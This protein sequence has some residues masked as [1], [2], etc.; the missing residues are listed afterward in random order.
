MTMGRTRRTIVG[1]DFDMSDPFLLGPPSL[2]RKPIF[3]SL[4]KKKGDFSA[5]FLYN[6][7]LGS[8]RN[9]DVAQMVERSLSMREVRGSIPRISTPCVLLF[10]FFFLNR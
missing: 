4:K 10:D 2:L 8:N 3:F 1:P 5:L 7:I 9:G 6:K